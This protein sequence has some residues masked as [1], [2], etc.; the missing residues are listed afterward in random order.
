MS[1]ATAHEAWRDGRLIDAE[2][3]YRIEADAGSWAA[4]FQL[5]WFDAVFARLSPEQVRAL[6]RPMLSPAAWLEA[7][8]GQPSPGAPRAVDRRSLS[9]AA[10]QRVELLASLCEGKVHLDGTLADWDIEALRARG[11]AETD[12][13][14]LERAHRAW[15]VGLYGLA[16]RCVDEAVERSIV[17]ADDK[18]HWAVGLLTQADDHLRAIA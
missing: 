2:R 4:R 1:L 16:D 6:E 10:R 13:W 7:A 17:L 5:A 8:F 12:D 11:A 14:W 3:D 18:P 9:P 15:R